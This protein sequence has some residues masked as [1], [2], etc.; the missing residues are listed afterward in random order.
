LKRIKIIQITGVFLFLIYLALFVL[1]VFF[2]FKLDSNIIVFS[3]LMAMISL[4]MLNKGVLLHSLSTLWFAIDLILN[5]LAMMLI[6]E[7]YLVHVNNYY[8]FSS[9]P[10]IPSLILLAVFRNPIYIK[11]IIL[12][13]FIIIS[14]VLWQEYMLNPLINV[15][16]F[17]AGVVLSVLVC[18]NLNFG[19]ENV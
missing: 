6:S 9:I 16:N 13:I 12:N 11:V 4:N 10:I 19:R 8:V 7:F 5:A 3:A 14:T 1:E 15:I 2:K 17:G 18:R